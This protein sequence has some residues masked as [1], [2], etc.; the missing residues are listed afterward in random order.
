MG[1]HQTVPHGG[2]VVEPMIEAAS[3]RLFLVV[4][5]AQ[6]GIEVGD[7][8]LYRGPFRSAILIFGRTGLKTSL[9]LV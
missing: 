4:A 6:G 2:P 5:K 3:P 9:V 1:V 7:H 8:F